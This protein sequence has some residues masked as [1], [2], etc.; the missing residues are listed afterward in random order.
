[1]L[2]VD[3]EPGI[4]RALTRLLQRDGHIVETAINGQAALA[5]LHEDD[6]D[7]ILCDL[8]MPELDGQTLYE[9][10]QRQH[11][12]LCP[13]MIF[14]TG[15]TLSPDSMRFVEQCGLPWIAKPCGME[16]IRAAIARVLSPP[17]DDTPVSTPPDDF[18][19]PF[20]LAEIQA[21]IDTT[22]QKR[23]DLHV[24]AAEPSHSRQHYEAFM[25]LAALLQEGLEEVRVISASLREGSQM[26]RGESADL[27]AYSTQL[28]EQCAR[29]ME[30]MAQFLPDHQEMQ[31]TERRMLDMF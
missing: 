1:M 23:L 30:C 16:E 12:T 5:R 22:K 2:V 29:S 25:D 21:W 26:V 19:Q 3:D 11:P 13:R 4:L 20:T 8:R 27:R 31:E 17:V 28:L 18:Q 6:Y 9:L 24:F 7:L 15:D 14:L 10:L